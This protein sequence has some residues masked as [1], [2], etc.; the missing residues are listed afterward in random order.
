MNPSQQIDQRI[1]E[2][3]DPPDGEA[4]WRGKVFAQLRKVILDADPDIKEDWKWGT[5]VWTHNGMI[6]AVG[7]MKDHVKINFFQGAALK[8]PSKLFNAGLEA[9]KTRAIDF[10]EG[11]KADEKKLTDL[12]KEAVEYNNK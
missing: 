3:T 8:D 2:L 10:F 6:C 7:A 5:G 1:T 9:K 11:D 4:R 12:I